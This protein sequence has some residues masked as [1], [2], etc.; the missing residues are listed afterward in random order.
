[1]KSIARA[2]GGDAEL[3]AAGGPREAPDLQRVTMDLHFGAR[4]APPTGVRS[5]DERNRVLG[6]RAGVRGD[7]GLH[8]FSLHMASVG[9]HVGMNDLRQVPGLA[10]GDGVVAGKLAVP[11]AV[12]P[13]VTARDELGDDSAL[14]LGYARH[15]ACGRP[16]RCRIA[17]FHDHAETQLV[18]THDDEI[19]AGKRCGTSQREEC[20]HGKALSGA[21]GQVSSGRLVRACS[22]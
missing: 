22:Q 12:K 14:M 21:H 11:V 4:R 13:Q 10:D 1:V 18:G 6:H 7:L 8:R 17:D 20:G 16:P 15:T 2:K 19:A 5:L 9:V 3:R